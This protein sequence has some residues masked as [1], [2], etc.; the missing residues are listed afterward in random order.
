MPYHIN[1][2]G[3]LHIII[4][5]SFVTVQ[6]FLNIFCVSSPVRC[7]GGREALY[8]PC[9]QSLISVF[10][11]SL[12]GNPQK[13]LSH[14]TA[15][16]WSHPLH[17]QAL[18]PAW[19][20]CHTLLCP[21]QCDL[22]AAEGSRRTLCSLCKRPFFF[23]NKEIVLQRSGTCLSCSSDAWEHVTIICEIPTLTNTVRRSCESPGQHQWCDLGGISQ[24]LSQ[25][26]C[27]PGSARCCQPTP[28]A[29]RNGRCMRSQPCLLP[30]FVSGEWKS[31][32]GSSRNNWIILWWDR[33]KL[34]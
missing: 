2:A 11:L 20:Y 10:P 4:A 17:F 1:T 23:P 34:I 6:G 5:N 32:G 15:T 14:P 3:S 27:S 22:K 24:H 13:V 28:G 31:P 8:F 9:I 21:S 18:C 25:L 7:F 16:L 12:A 30:A 29:V 19:H 26:W 33:V